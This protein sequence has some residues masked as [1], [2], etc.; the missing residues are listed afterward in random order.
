MGRAFHGT[1]ASFGGLL[2]V[3]TQKT[4]LQSGFR[5]LLVSA[6][7]E[8]KLSVH[9]ADQDFGL[10]TRGAANRE[11]ESRKRGGGVSPKKGGRK[12]T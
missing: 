8:E 2:L 10:P 3:G 4:K 7:S 6:D 5:R 9:D 12:N 11:V 1:W